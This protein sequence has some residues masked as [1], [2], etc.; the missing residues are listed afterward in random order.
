MEKLLMTTEEVCQAVSLSR[1]SLWRLE[2]RGEF[3]RRRQISA[4]RVGWI[5]SE[6]LGW[7]ESRPEAEPSPTMAARAVGRA[8]KNRGARERGDAA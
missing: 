1:T 8:G 3:P 5:R 7:I 2:R 6:I 4:Q